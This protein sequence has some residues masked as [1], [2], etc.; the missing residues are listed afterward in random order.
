MYEIIILHLSAVK[1]SSTLFMWV[2]YSLWLLATSC[3]FY[4]HTFIASITMVSKNKGKVCN[5][6]QILCYNL[7][8]NVLMQSSL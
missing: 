6:I 2:I 5:I 4:F 1:I 7:D 8:L 3:F